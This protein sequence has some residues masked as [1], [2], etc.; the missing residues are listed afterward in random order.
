MYA[1]LLYRLL[2]LSAVHFFIIQ[3]SYSQRD[4]ENLHSEQ[5]Y[6]QFIIA[7]APSEDALVALQRLA[8]PYIDNKDWTGAVGVF[9][10][11]I[12]R[13]GDKKERILKVVDLLNATSQ[14]LEITNLTNIN[15]KGGEY[16]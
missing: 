6:I 15:T 8:Q 11:Y 4:L 12:N 3:I 13:F 2:I 10:K 16:F 14:N 5:D 7:T 1:K 9:N